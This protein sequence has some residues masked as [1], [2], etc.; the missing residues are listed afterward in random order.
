MREP[1]LIRGISSVG[2]AEWGVGGGIRSACD[3]RS[4]AL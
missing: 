3:K 1:M 4:F 2:G